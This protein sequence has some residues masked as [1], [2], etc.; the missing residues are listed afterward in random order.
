MQPRIR[1]T[2]R[3][4][5]IGL[6]A[7]SALIAAGIGVPAVASA[8]TPTSISSAL[9]EFGAPG[10]GP[11]VMVFT[12][13]APQADVQAAFDAVSAQQVSNQFGPERYTLLFAPGTYGSAAEPLVVQ[14]GYYEQVAGLGADPGDVVVNGAV[15]V[16]NQ[17]D[18]TSGCIALNNFWRSLSNLT[19]NPT[20]SSGCRA[21]TEF[22]AVSQA[23]PMR[24]VQVN[25]TTTLMDYCTAGPQYA[26]GGFIADSAFSGQVVNGSQQQFLVRNSSI[27]GWSNGVW[28]QVFSGVTGA[29]T[30]TFGQSGAQPYTT[31]ATTPVT[32][33]TPFL[34][35]SAGG[36]YSVRVPDA[37][38]DTSGTSWASD[39][40]AR[41]VPLRDFFVATPRTPVAQVN[42]ALARG[43]DL[44]LSPGVYSYAEPIRVVHP[45]TV[46]MGLGFATLVPT[47]G[48]HALDL[49]GAAGSVVTGLV[50][51]AGPRG[52]RTLLDV[53]RGRSGGQ[54]TLVSDVFF[55]VG[56]ATAGRTDTALTV[57]ASDVVLDDVWAWRADHGTGVG[58][59]S[60]RSDTG[61]V[62]NGDRVTATGLFVE[63]FQKTE[64]QWNGEDG[65]VVF[66]QNEMPY[67]VPSQAAWNASR[68]TK[69]YPALAISPR[70]RSF[71]GS[72]MGSY[73]F[74]D[75]GVDV[76]ASEAFTTSGRSGIVMH[77]LLTRFLNGS[78]GIDS[79][80]DGTGA[81]V[82]ATNP[83]P[84]QVVDAH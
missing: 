33:E 51:D 63:H 74:F 32:R 52:S 65:R 82:D 15:N 59:S 61:V 75:Q 73:S 35:R 43:S 48:G 67:D 58:W 77:D 10:L 5:A 1:S 64:V 34:V 69:G 37:T 25:G 68:N 55:R 54:P 17:C 13:S 3:H 26:S 49:R 9:Q 11:N 72:G 12:P 29:P 44:L 57:D 66:F 8:A 24:R 19:I 53:G 50:L 4:I 42:R 28:N 78:G 16:L 23:S 21:D 46:V 84:A 22:W 30:E 81:A 2:L 45:D 31:L 47:A 38:E 27:G 14:V 39:A 41:S 7:G 6:T 70:V 71:H 62:V 60:N 83:G 79:V 40:T 20:G 76:H 80:I 56:G 18:A 36:S